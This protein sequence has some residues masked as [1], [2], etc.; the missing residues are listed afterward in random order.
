MTWSRNG[1]L[2]VRWCELTYENRFGADLSIISDSALKQMICNVLDNA[3][4]ASPQWVGFEVTH[5]GDLL[6]MVVTRCGAGLCAGD[7]GAFRQTLPIH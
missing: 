7:A 2:L 4:E 3:L 1:A 5:E 6:K